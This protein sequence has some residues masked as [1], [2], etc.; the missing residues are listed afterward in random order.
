VSCGRLCDSVA[1]VDGMLKS[2]SVSG[3]VCIWDDPFVFSSCAPVGPFHSGCG[4]R[5]MILNRPVPIFAHSQMPRRE[6]VR[7]NGWTGPPSH[8]NP[9]SSRLLS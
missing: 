4:V 5:P 6:G 1:V 3:I 9:A 8:S 7:C 2:S